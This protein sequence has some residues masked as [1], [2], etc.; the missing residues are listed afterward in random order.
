MDSISL[1]SLSGNIQ[2]ASQ[3][4][5]NFMQ[6]PAVHATTSCSLNNVLIMSR[7][8]SLNPKFSLLFVG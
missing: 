8:N 7:I 3:L 1:Q 2:L 4:I 6:L 5:A